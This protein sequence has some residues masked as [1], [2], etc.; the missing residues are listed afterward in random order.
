M[1]GAT[2]LCGNRTFGIHGVAGIAGAI[3]LVFYLR[4]MPEHGLLTQLWYQAKGVLVADF[5]GHR[6][7]PESQYKDFEYPERSIPDSPGFHQEWFN[8]AKGGDTPPTCHFDYSGPMTESVLLGN[9]A[10][11]VGEAFDWDGENMKASS[12]KAQALLQRT[13]RKGWQIT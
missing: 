7:Y 13:Y 9:V 8:A 5:G 11:R 6:L 3:M 12:A 10:Y 2:F 1:D 4:D